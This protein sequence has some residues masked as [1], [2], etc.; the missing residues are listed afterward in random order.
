[1]LWRNNTTGD[2]GYWSISSS[3]PTWHEVGAS[4]TNYLVA[5][6]ADFGGNGVSDVLWRNNTTGDTGYWSISNSGPSWHELGASATNYVV[7]SGLHP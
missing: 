2:T 5:A 6:I 3:G 7:A 1:V 4:A